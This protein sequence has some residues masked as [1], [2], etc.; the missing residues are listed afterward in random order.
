MI[1][2]H[3]GLAPVLDVARDARWGR[4]EETFGEDPYLTGVMATRY[5]RGLQGEKRDMLATLKHF[6]GHSARWRTLDILGSQAQ[7]K[8]SSPISVA[9]RSIGRRR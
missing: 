4:T 2:C 7:P 3:Q 8:P 6:A 9:D 1:G 5:V